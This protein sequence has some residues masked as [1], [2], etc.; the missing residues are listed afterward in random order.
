MET[1][2]MIL[3]VK[4]LLN[5]N[6]SNTNENEENEEVKAPSNVDV[7]V[8]NMLAFCYQEMPHGM[9]IQDWTRESLQVLIGHIF[10]LP[11]E[12]SDV[13]PIAQLSEPT[14]VIPRE[15][16]FPKER[17]ETKWEKFR[18][19]KG[20]PKRK[21][22]SRV[23]DNDVKDWRYRYG[24]KRK[25]DER[26]EWVVEDNENALRESGAEDPF[27]MKKNE[28]KEK[29]EKQ[30]KKQVSNTLRSQKLLDKK[31]LPGVVG[32]SNKGRNDYNDIKR[33]INLAQ[34]STGSLGYF[35]NKMDDEPQ[36][37]R[38]PKL[39]SGE[40]EQK[41][42]IK[43][44]KSVIKKNKGSDINIRKAVN[45]SIAEEQRNSKNHKKRRTK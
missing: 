32:L 10:K 35:D 12:R 26:L 27:I 37:K 24:N 5:K 16:P 23:W 30:R 28:K 22:S 43:I 1:G 15:K 31:A 18:R 7:D 14:T 17:P 25:N 9:G 44:A 41:T 42:N 4:S 40:N 39:V 6:E 2:E 11:V 36:I 20:I 3:D 21:K 34:K 45:R 8:G 38:K 19:N 29:I 33:A 13:G